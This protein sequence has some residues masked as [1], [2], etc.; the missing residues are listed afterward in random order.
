MLKKIRILDKRHFVKDNKR[1]RERQKYFI[2]VFF[3]RNTFN[4]SA[5]LSIFNVKL[6][7]YVVNYY[8]KTRK[9]ERRFQILLC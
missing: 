8:D 9:K 3:F 7:M 4:T 5:F 2:I 1:K 6:A